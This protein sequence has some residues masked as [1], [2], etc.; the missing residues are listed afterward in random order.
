MCYSSGS[1]LNAQVTGVKLQKCFY[2]FLL[3]SLFNYSKASGPDYYL[4]KLSLTHCLQIM[5]KQSPVWLTS[6]TTVV[7]REQ[8]VQHLNEIC[9]IFLYDYAIFS[10]N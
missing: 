2:F 1:H 7:G 5:F 9:C 3:E 8:I 10:H 6:Y 4:T